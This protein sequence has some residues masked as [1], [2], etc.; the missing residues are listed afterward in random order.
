MIVLR[1]EQ[2][3]GEQ[4]GRQRQVRTLQASGGARAD[5]GGGGA[6]GES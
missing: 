2:A 5:G 3:V 4:E 6:S 1:G